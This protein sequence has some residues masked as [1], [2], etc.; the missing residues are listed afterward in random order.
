MQHKEEYV[1]DLSLVDTYVFDYGGVVSHHYCEPWQSNLAKLLN[2]DQKKVHDLLSE[3]SPQGK[4]YRLGKMSRSQ[5]WDEIMKLS[6]TSDVSIEDLANNWA[7]S[8]QIDER[9]LNVIERLR[10]E[11]TFQVGVLM[12]SDEYRH[13]HI[14]KEYA[15]SS[16]LDFLVSSFIHSVTK[17]DLEAYATVL[18]LANRLDDPEKVLYLDDREKNVLP[19]LELG[20]QG[21][22]YSTYE[23]FRRFLLINNV[24]K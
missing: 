2:V 14:E 8:Y 10:S 21:Y 7:R 19:V 15:L 6:G 13:K 18:R 1:Q 12:N 20:M 23:E 3:T 17:P 24:L 9:M 11:K 22:V 5:F 4:D 16:K